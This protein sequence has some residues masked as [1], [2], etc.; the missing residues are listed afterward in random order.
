VISPIILKTRDIGQNSYVTSPVGKG[1]SWVGQNSYK[2]N[3]LPVKITLGK[4]GQNQ[5]E[6]SE[7]RYSN[8]LCEIKINSKLHVALVLHKASQ[9]INV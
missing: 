4:R 7:T 2:S 8:P 9:S 5:P 3:S 6:W 1:Y